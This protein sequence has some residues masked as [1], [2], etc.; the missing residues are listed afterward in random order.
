MTNLTDYI[1]DSCKTKICRMMDENEIEMTS[2]N[3]DEVFSGS[4]C[5]PFENL[6][7][8]HQQS[9]FVKYKLPYVVSVSIRYSMLPQLF[10][11]L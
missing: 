6:K 5:Q 3:L 10:P 7:T 1:L 9:Q 4:H 8:A 2:L 11:I